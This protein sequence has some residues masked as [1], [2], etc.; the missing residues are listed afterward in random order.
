MQIPQQY[1]EQLL[2]FVRLKRGRVNNIDSGLDKQF[3]I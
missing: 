3:A 2:L 1:V